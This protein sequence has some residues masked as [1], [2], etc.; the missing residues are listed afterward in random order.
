MKYTRRKVV[1]S[2]AVGAASLTIP[3]LV[4][5][6]EREVKVALIAPLSGPWARSGELMKIGAD[7]GIED[8]NKQGGVKLNGGMKM[9]LIAA[10]AG[11]SVE[12]AKNAAQR[13]I[14]QEPD[15][16]AGT[17]A[18]L[19]SF[20]M[21]VTEVTERAKLPWLTLSYADGI[22]ARGF[23]YLIQTNAISSEQA[24]NAMPAV[25]DLAEHSTGQRPKNVAFIGDNTATP[26]AFLNPLRQGGFEKLGVKI[27]SDQTYTPPLSDATSLVQALRTARLR[28]DFLIFYSTNTPDAALVL[29]KL[30]EFG[31]PQSKLP[32]VAPGAV[33][34]GAPEILKNVSPTL[35][36]GTILVV[37]NWTSKKQS[38]ILPDIV[39][40]SGEPWL[41]SDVISTYGDMWL[42]K[43]AI[44]RAGSTDREKVM[45]QLRATN[46]SAGAAR[47]Y[48]GG[49]LKFDEAGRRIGAPT[50]L[51]QWRDGKPVTVSPAEDAFMAPLWPRA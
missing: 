35:L 5:A 29:Q 18:W 27:I 7:I 16:V 10:D 42:I 38:D 24:K 4:R 31:L 45:E 9:R 48:L 49:N 39:K 23:R 46:L 21:A 32:L 30:H 15:V 28:P 36:E 43:D 41:T 11:D 44:E 8:I 3:G 2:M 26:Q 40:R 25:L 51:V 14:A 34:L 37:A 12:R 20:T 19:S 17:G 6:Q 1:G 22:T 50:V 47:Y 33:H 13:L